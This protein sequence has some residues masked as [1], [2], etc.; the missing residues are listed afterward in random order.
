MLAPLVLPVVVGALIMPFAG[1]RRGL[2]VALLWLLGAPM[3]W[4]DWVRLWGVKGA[5]T[6]RPGEGLRLEVER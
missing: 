6:D 3:T 4:R 5:V 2:V 1:V